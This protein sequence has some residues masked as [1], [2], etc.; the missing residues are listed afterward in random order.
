M[1][2]GPLSVDYDPVRRSR[3]APHA[4]LA[5]EETTLDER[6]PEG[7]QATAQEVRAPGVVK[8]EK[9][10][11][12]VEPPTKAQTDAK[13]GWFLKH[14]HSFTYAALFIFTIVLYFRPFEFYPNA[15]T[16]RL[17][18]VTGLI[19]LA[20]YVPTQLILEGTLTARPREVNLVMLLWLFAIISIVL[21]IDPLNSWSIFS[22]I[23]T[24][25]ILI[26]IIMVNVVRTERRLRGLLFLVLAVSCLLSVA[27]LSDYSSGNTVVEGYRVEGYI[28]GLF[29]NPNDLALHL[30]TIVPL[31]I[32]FFLSARFPLT[33]LAY[34]VCALLMVGAIVVTFSRTG[35][36]GL[37][38]AITVLAWKI[39]HRHRLLIIILLVVGVVLLF[40]LAPDEYSRRVASIVNSSTDRTG[41]Y[42]SRKDI[43]IR[44]LEVAFWNPVFGVGIGN[45]SIVS[46]R[47][48]VNH[49]AYLQV[50]SEMGLL[51]MVVYVMF[52][53]TPFKKLRQIE[54]E[55]WT[56]G[57]RPRAYYLAIGLQASLVAYMVSS[58]FS[59]VAYQWF[60]YYLVAYS[61]CLRRIYEA[62]RPAIAND[63][64]GIENERGLK[65]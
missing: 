47:G 11:P 21:A 56:P 33:K 49:N 6:W 50:A 63:D 57:R 48:A 16:A 5:T 22:D 3:R 12:R 25:A 40:S 64:A 52:I 35:F 27:A 37:L 53:L 15:V 29:S 23:F 51:A 38:C 31:A 19:T 10:L 4:A 42:F 58:F 36:L 30:A 26:F 18:F 60:I 59:S 13:Q 65:V 20:I 39:G 41:S 61:V 1:P 8:V 43:L 2:H 14:G 62:G 9:T 46:I 44:S 32:A 7:A 34:G 45:F 17:A 24:K 28:K 55:T 54:R